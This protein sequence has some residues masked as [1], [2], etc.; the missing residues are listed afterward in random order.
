MRKRLERFLA[1]PRQE[2]W[3]L[4]QAWCL[5]PLTEVALGLLSFPVLERGMERLARSRKPGP[6]GS[7]S[8]ERCRELVEIAARHQVGSPGCLRRA[9]VLG[10]LLALRAIPGQVRFGV[11]KEAGAFQAHAWL[12]VGGRPLDVPRR[13]ARY[14]PL[15]PAPPAASASPVRNVDPG[16]TAG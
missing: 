4:C 13:V 11:R 1:L 7:P 9:L 3:L 14:S 2:R 12:E 10:W 8:P 6:P 15:L 5:L 16:G